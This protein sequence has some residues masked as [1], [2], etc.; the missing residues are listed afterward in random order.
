MPYH[1]KRKPYVNYWFSSTNGR[2]INEFLSCISES[3]QDRLEKEGG[4]C[5]MYT[6]FADGFVK[7]GS[8]NEDFKSLMKRLSNKK[9]FFV[10]VN[11]ILDYL[12]INKQQK[13]ASSDDLIS[14]ERSWLVDKIFHG[15]N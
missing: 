3:N 9:G 15:R 2:N 13:N 12:L 1:D 5:I 6:H 10:P 14:L 8:L 11:Q 7:D 4:A